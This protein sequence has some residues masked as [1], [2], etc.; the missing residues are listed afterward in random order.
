MENADKQEK[1]VWG[2]VSG[3]PWWPGVITEEH[4]NEHLTVIF[5][6]DFSY[7][8]LPLEK[9]KPFSDLKGKFD[10]KNR[11]LVTAIRTAEQIISGELSL[12][13][14]LINGQVK[15]TGKKP[16]VTTKIKKKPKIKKIVILKKDKAT[17][18]KVIDNPE[19]SASPS[20]QSINRKRKYSEQL[21]C[22]SPCPPSFRQRKATED[23]AFCETKIMDLKNSIFSDPKM[24]SNLKNNS[25]IEISAVVT[26]LLGLLSALCSSIERRTISLTDV[27]SRLIKIQLKLQKMTPTDFQLAA[28]QGAASQL[29]KVYDSILSSKFDRRY[30]S[31]CLSMVETLVKD[32][33]NRLQSGGSSQQIE[34]AV[35][36]GESFRECRFLQIEDPITMEQEE[37]IKKPF[38]EDLKEEVKTVVEDIKKEV[39]VKPPIELE[40]VEPKVANRVCRKIARVFLKYRP[41]SSFSKKH[42]EILT[43]ML[44][45]LLVENS[46]DSKAYRRL[47]VRAVRA[48]DS[49]DSL[50]PTLF[51]KS[52][53]KNPDILYLEFSNLIN[54]IL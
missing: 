27:S 50:A 34:L 43:L 5:F 48:L 32:F 20:K 1:V 14:V 46:C 31:Y 26:K 41:V 6:E 11:K 49:K 45:Q 40:V 24:N 13:D 53:D 29:I 19:S 2:K 52:R 28:E 10:K 38:E 44:H 42:C 39:T 22:E 16:K 36:F 37:N 9:V 8:I 18:N 15:Q 51:Y 30:V 4:S 35:S 23:N 12:S 54:Q 21:N 3:Y 7:S 25:Q 17:L 33:K 47:T